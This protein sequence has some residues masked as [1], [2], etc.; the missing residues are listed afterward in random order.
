MCGEL[1]RK[2]LAGASA[3]PQQSADRDS[4]GGRPTTTDDDAKSS[5][6]VQSRVH[7]DVKII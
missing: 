5:A 2:R 4:R 3:E 6:A 1:G 7:G